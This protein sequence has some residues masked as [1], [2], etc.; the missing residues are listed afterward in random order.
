VL[1]WNPRPAAVLLAAA[2]LPGAAW[3]YK[4]FL[5]PR[6]F[7]IRHYDPETIYFYGAFSLL[8]GGHIWTVD[9]PGIP[10]YLLSALLLKLTGWGPLDLDA[11]RLA[12]YCTAAA[13]WAAGAWLL[14][15]TLLKNLPPL[16]Q[17]AALWTYALQP[18]ALEYSTI[19][20]PE[21]FFFP[22]G[23]LA[24]AAISVSAED[25]SRRRVLA[26]GAAVGLC[27]ALKFTFFG[28]LI[29]LLFALLATP[30][31][32]W[33]DRLLAVGT[34][35]G[36]W[37]A[38]F[39]VA[40]LA[41]AS[42]YETM[43]ARMILFYSH[44]GRYGEGPP[45]RFGLKPIIGNLVSILRSE[46]ESVNGCAGWGAWMAF[47]SLVLAASLRASAQRGE[48]PRRMVFLTVFATAAAV[49]TLLL[50][51]T[52][53]RDPRYAMPLATVGILLAAL[54]LE[55]LP[56]KDRAPLQWAAI[57]VTGLALCATLVKDLHRHDMLIDAGWGERRIT[58]KALDDAG[59]DPQRDT[60]VYGWRVHQPSFALRLMVPIMTR[61]A[62]RKRLLGEIES[63]YP[64][65]GHTSPDY[66]RLL[67]PAGRT[68]WDFLMVREWFLRLPRL[69]YPVGP[70][71][72]QADGYVI[73]GRPRTGTPAR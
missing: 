31:R 3:V 43:A 17:I 62:L 27:V 33:R 48:I 52:R 9:H 54:A 53:S 67:L 46:T 68:G 10:V 49:A 47:A 66:R 26:A 11:F 21:L 56:G 36:G 19:W 41:A 50:V 13:L 34:A 29:A 18:L 42:R 12:G 28:F 38:G 73:L 51:A 14:L 64:R 23:A 25:C 35:F 58:Q 65:E 60:V 15:R 45:A 8:D 7:W 16:L 37:A 4:V 44:S 59:W 30:G 1:R 5:H 61:G 57:S 72:S 22:A 2:V 40:T 71:L 32:P 70:V 69:P 20:S 63:A 55:A 24:L 6:P 39:L